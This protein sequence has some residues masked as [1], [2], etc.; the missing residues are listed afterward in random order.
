MAAEFAVVKTVIEI[1]SPIVKGFLDDANKKDKS[2]IERC[3]NYLRAAQYA[4]DGLSREFEE[5]VQK[6]RICDLQ[7]MEQVESLRK[8]VHEYLEL[9][10][11]RPEML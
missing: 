4:A 7:K 9:N 8:R 11:L 5:I 6:A 1:T 3:V 10:I 2:Q